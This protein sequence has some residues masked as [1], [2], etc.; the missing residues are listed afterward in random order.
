MREMSL[1]AFIAS[2]VG[3]IATQIILRKLGVSLPVDLTAYA[4]LL[5]LQFLTMALGYVFFLFFPKIGSFR[6]S[7]FGVMLLQ[8]VVLT[9][10]SVSGKYLVVSAV[11]FFLFAALQSDLLYREFRVFRAEGSFARL[12]LIIYSGSA[13]GLLAAEK[14][15]F[16]FVPL[17][18]VL[19]LLGAVQATIAVGFLLL[20][21]SR[22][23]ETGTDYGKAEVSLLQ[24]VWRS[25]LAGYILFAGLVVAY[26]L[27][28]IYLRDTADVTAEITAISMIIAALVSFRFV[29]LTH[30][31][32]GAKFFLLL[33]GPLLFTVVGQNLHK[34][35][36]VPRE[37]FIAILLAGIS[38]WA[39][40][41]YNESIAG[42]RS[43][44]QVTVILLSNTLGSF[45]G[46]V[47]FGYFIIPTFKLEI[48]FGVFAAIFATS[49]VVLLLQDLP[50][51]SD[52]RL[53]GIGT[54]AIAAF[55]FLMLIPFFMTHWYRVQIEAFAKRIVPDE[56][57]I[58]SAETPQDL[59]ALTEKKFHDELVYHRLLHNSHSMSGT[60]FPSRRYMKLMAYLG[61]MY[62]D[63]ATTALNIGFGTGLT[64]QALLENPALNKLDVSDVTR[65]IEKLTRII[66]ESEPSADPL[67][68]KRLAYHTGG[69]RHFLYTHPEKFDIIT[70]E[71]PPPSNSSIAYLYT[72]EF[73]REILNHLTPGGVFTYWLPT[74]SVS[75][76]AAEKI[77]R[78]FCAVFPHADLYAGTETNLI[79]VGYA[80][81]GGR[82]RMQSRAAAVIN[83]QFRRETNLQSV[84]DIEAL[85]IEGKTLSPSTGLTNLLTDDFSYIEEDYGH[86]GRRP[87]KLP[88]LNVRPA[89]YSADSAANFYTGL[90]ALEKVVPLRPS[91]ATIEWLMGIDSRT[92][93]IALKKNLPADDFYSISLHFAD[94]LS[95]MDY[96]GALTFLSRFEQTINA[97]EKLFAYV[98]LLE[99]LQ[100]LDEQIIKRNAVTFARN[101]RAVSAL[102]KKYV[103]RKLP[104]AF[105]GN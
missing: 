29:Q 41:V 13:L 51:I 87:W 39:G 77:W 3:L 70:G 43:S 2:F 68:D 96:S 104:P 55:V 59:W 63:N 42:A 12:N 84:Q 89:I 101:K 86:P 44:R 10:L 61:Y 97:D 72:A 52:R 33:V 93:T 98:V 22:A 80:K 16:K 57:L 94:Y 50:K 65:D 21:K 95:R 38:A 4:F 32:K 88:D 100:N 62:S 7:L 37:F 102:F 76:S 48:S 30:S 31:G 34:L 105:Y 47:S 85:F 27:L 54:V 18:Y 11:L 36:G 67:R 66:F 49:A 14:I 20:R 15:I 19:W 24:S 71:P 69:I 35:T 23:N 79:M 6:K 73:Y 99:R 81:P 17:T 46:A 92:K 74:H 26:R 82:A 60:F 1:I 28:R 75:D 8:A 5:C 45:A 9:V 53:R 103:D 64:A 83:P 91:L 40:F 90:I 58:A 78:T 56:Q 25:S